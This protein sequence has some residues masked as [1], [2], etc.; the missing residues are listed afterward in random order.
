MAERRTQPLVRSHRISGFHG[1]NTV[2]SDIKAMEDG[3]SP[4]A[5]NWITGTEQDCIILRRGT[6]I[7]GQTDRGTGKVTGLGVGK[8]NNGTEVPFF[9]YGRKAFYYDAT[10]DDSIEISTDLLPAAASGLDVSV[11][12]YQNLAGSAVFMTAPNLPGY[13]IMVANPGSALDQGLTDY[14]GYVKFGQSRSLLTARTSSAGN[15]DDKSGLY[16]S[17]VDKVSVSSYTLVTGESFG[18][19]GSTSYSHTA[20][21]KAAKESIFLATVTATVAAGTETFTDNGNGVLTSNF[22]GTGTINYATGAMSV[23]FSAVTTGAVTCSYYRADETSGGVLDFSFTSPTR[24][25]GEGRYFSQFDGGGVLNAVFPLASVFY[26]FHALKTWQTTIPTDDDDTGATPATNLPFRERMGVSYPYSVYGTSTGIH[27]V[28]N[29]NPSLPEVYTLRLYT[30]AT[31]ANIAAPELI[32]KQLDLSSYAFDKA[33]VFQWGIYILV[34]CQRIRNGATDADNSRTLIYNQRTGVWDMTDYAATRF[35][36]YNGQLLGG[37]P[38]SNNVY[39]LFSGF[40]DLAEN[41]TNYWTSGETNHGIE[42]QK[43]TTTMVVDGLIQA[44]QS[45]DVA[46][47]FDGGDFVTVKTI[48][49]TGTYVDSSRSVAVGSQTMGSKDVGGGDTIYASPFH[50][51]FPMNSDRYEYVRVRLQ[52]TGGGYAQVNYYE[53]KDIRLKSARSMPSRITSA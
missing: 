8:L 22:G 32:S 38:Y 29:A 13:K 24:T 4:D 17:H 28:N 41:V 10:S 15:K 27:Y 12:R 51:E 33:V 3:Y 6:K 49:G 52:A 34:S 37:D 36:E 35:A 1:L 48:S 31:A 2:L 23:T 25:A 39:V 9:T 46:L 45:I 16:M 14:R 19:S 43:R 42:G 47:S 18:S 5:L 53:Y 30:G 44:P 20:S 7:L 40:D 26:S 50:I 11:E 21:A